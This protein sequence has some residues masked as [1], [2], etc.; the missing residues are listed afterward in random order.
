MTDDAVTI[1]D[2]GRP[3]V[4][5]FIGAESELAETR[6]WA[7]GLGFTVTDTLSEDV[8][9]AVVTENVLDGLCSPT[10]AVTRSRA[11]EA[12]LPLISLYNA[13][14]VLHTHPGTTVTGYPASE[15]PAMHGL[16]I[17][18]TTL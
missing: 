13:K 11:E 14:G 1:N 16:R 3:R 15:N 7:T 6:T 4:L 10:D 17:V 8:D 12:G 5:L 18:D 2:S 9:C